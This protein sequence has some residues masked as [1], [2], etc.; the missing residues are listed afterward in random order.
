MVEY[1]VNRGYGGGVQLQRVCRMLFA[2]HVC[3]DVD[4]VTEAIAPSA[5]DDI[6]VPAQARDRRVVR[7]YARQETPLSSS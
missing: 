4:H 5:S 3:L 2:L 1:P 7:G 6:F